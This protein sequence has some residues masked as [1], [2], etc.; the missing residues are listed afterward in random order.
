MTDRQ[1]QSELVKLSR[2]FSDR[3]F[4]NDGNSPFCQS[5]NSVLCASLALRGEASVGKARILGE[6]G[7][8]E[9]KMSTMASAIEK[10]SKTLIKWRHFFVGQI[11]TRTLGDATQQR[12]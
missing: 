4:D 8:L 10:F 12:I 11:L 9:Q 3:A 7:S 5:S 1:K 2:S 6:E